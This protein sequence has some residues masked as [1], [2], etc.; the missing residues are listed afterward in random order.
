MKSKYA[1]YRL[2]KDNLCLARARLEQLEEKPIEITA[3]DGIESLLFRDKTRVC[4]PE[5]NGKKAM[6]MNVVYQREFPEYLKCVVEGIP[7]VHLFDV[8]ASTARYLYS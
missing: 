1:K 2:S 3:C 6:M 5:E 7:K 8:S 4:I